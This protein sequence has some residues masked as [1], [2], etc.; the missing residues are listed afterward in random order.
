MSPAGD[1]RSLLRP[2]NK[3]PSSFA[4][5]GAVAYAI[6]PWK[7]WSLRLVAFVSVAAGDSRA[8]GRLRDRLD[9]LAGG[10]VTA[11]T[12]DVGLREHADQFVLADDDRQASHLLA[13]HQRERLVQV[14]LRSERDEVA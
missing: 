13:R 10:L 14:V 7:I 6:E 1:D 5:P 4:T 8:A 3:F 9:H 12:C 2:L 11:G